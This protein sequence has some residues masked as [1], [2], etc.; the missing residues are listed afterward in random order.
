MTTYR[1]IK[2]GAMADRPYHFMN[3]DNIGSLCGR[4]K[5]GD[6]GATTVCCAPSPI[7]DG[8]VCAACRDLAANT[9]SG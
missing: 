8:L 6:R 2:K 5:I 3:A 1:Y 9:A 7:S 4:V